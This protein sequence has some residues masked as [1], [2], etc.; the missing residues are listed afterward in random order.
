MSAATE[1]EVPPIKPDKQMDFAF[2]LMTLKDACIA[3]LNAVPSRAG[4]CTLLAQS[5]LETKQW[6]RCPNYNWA[7]IKHVTGDGHPWA[8]HMTT[9]GFGDG[10]VHLPQMFRAY[11]DYAEGARDY[12]SFL[13]HSYKTHDHPQGRYAEAWAALASPTIFVLGLRSG[14]YFSGNPQVYDRD[15]EA[16]WGKFGVLMLGYPPGPEGV[17]AFQEHAGIGVDGDIG[18]ITRAALARVL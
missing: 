17:K 5:A 16:Y 7:G 2:A 10:T 9:E 13:A 18:P 8:W 6:T 12:V 3:V 1:R 14:G 15:V 4:L 11:E